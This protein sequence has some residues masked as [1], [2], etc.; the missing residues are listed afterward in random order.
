[1]KIKTIAKV[2]YGFFAAAFLLVGITV[3]DRTASGSDRI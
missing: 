2:V 1:M 3:H